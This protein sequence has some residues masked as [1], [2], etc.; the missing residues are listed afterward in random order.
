[1]QGK[2]EKSNS[3][4]IVIKAEQRNYFSDR[5]PNF[6]VYYPVPME[7]PAFAKAL[8]STAPGS[9]NY[10]FPGSVGLLGYRISGKTWIVDFAQASFFMPRAPSLNRALAS[11]HGGWRNHL[12]EHLFRKAKLFGAREIDFGYKHQGKGR[13]FAVVELFLKKAR[14]HGFQKTEQSVPG[15]CIVKKTK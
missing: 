15:H 2:T 4:A 8:E 3:K 11:K 1:K 6:L 5:V 13:R 12:F 9:E 10:R 7:A 14:E